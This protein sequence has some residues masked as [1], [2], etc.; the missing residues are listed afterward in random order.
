MYNGLW[1]YGSTKILSLKFKALSTDEKAQNIRKKAAP[2]G[3][4]TNKPFIK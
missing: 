3:K 1:L 4:T 2:S